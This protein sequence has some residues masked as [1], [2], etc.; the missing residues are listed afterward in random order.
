MPENQETQKPATWDDKNREVILDPVMR[1]RERIRSITRCAEYMGCP[2]MVRGLIDNGISE[3]DAMAAIYK[4]HLASV[5]EAMGYRGPVDDNHPATLMHD[6]VDKRVEAMTDGQLMRAGIAVKNPAGGSENF[7]GST[8]RDLAIEC[9]R[10]E[11]RYRS[12][13]STVK[14]FSEALSSRAL[15]TGDLPY[16]MSNLSGK[17]A[18]IGFQETPASYP[19]LVRVGEAT[20]FKTQTRAKLSEGDSLEEIPEL[21][22]YQYGERAEHYEQ[23][24]IATYGKIFA[25]SRQALINDDLGLL[26]GIP[27]QHGAAARRKINSLV[28]SVL[29]GNA[30]MS[31]GDAL[32]HA[33]H[34]NFVAENSG[35]APGIET[36]T[37]AYQA[38]RLQQGPQGRGT[39]H[40]AEHFV[41]PRGL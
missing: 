28:L 29:T 26:T 1:E 35:A 27:R 11:G 3:N 6:Q 38:M 2:E 13:M 14:I 37:A 41:D 17:S 20:N 7:R 15:T 40:P 10:A 22:D 8:F 33:N 32:F 34:N 18:M 36:L 9:L 23:F 5:P 19:A 30:A 39:E 16:I 21:G 12:G 24:S 4:R 31:D 25:I